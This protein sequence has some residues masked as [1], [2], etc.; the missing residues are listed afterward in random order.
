M[1]VEE[2]GNPYTASSLIGLAAVL[3]KAKSG[4]LIFL[5]SYG[6]GAGSDGLILR[7]TAKINKKSRESSFQQQKS[8]KK[9]ISYTDYLK[10][11]GKI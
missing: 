8:G 2:I 1:I 5:V 7:V 9:Y 3:D 4:D 10:F 11:R 6:S